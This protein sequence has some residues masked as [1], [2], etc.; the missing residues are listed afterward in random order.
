MSTNK[1]IPFKSK[2]PNPDLPVVFDI[3]S[4]ELNQHRADVRIIDVRRPDE[5]VGEY[6]HIA[7]AELITL[8]TLPNRIHELN[9][10][11]IVVFVCRSGSRS[12]QAAAFAME[13]GIQNAYNMKGGM[14]DWTNKRF[15]AVEKNGG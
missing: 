3:S 5:W 8:N 4:D 2:T 14:I 9:K 12:A 7:E 1:S 15:T 6:G 11:E 10:D 13:N